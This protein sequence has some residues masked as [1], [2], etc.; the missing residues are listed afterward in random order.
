[1]SDKPTKPQKLVVKG[2]TLVVTIKGARRE[3]PAG[4]ELPPEVDEKTRADALERD[5]IEVL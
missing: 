1:M 4:S 5:L 2:C 3:L